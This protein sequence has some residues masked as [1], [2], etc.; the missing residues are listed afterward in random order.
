MNA[1]NDDDE[2]DDDEDGESKRAHVKRQSFSTFTN[3][4][5]NRPSANSV[6]TDPLY[7]TQWHLNRGARGGFDMNVKPAWDLGYTGRGVVV[8]I[9]DDGIQTERKRTRPNSRP[10]KQD[11][12]EH[13]SRSL[14]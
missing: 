6:I 3:P 4:R 5:G 10:P 8:T 13:V 1:D 12:R 11:R 7:R 9:L 2:D 14:L